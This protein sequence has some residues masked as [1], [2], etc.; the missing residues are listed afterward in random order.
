MTNCSVCRDLLVLEPAEQ[1]HGREWLHHLANHAGRLIPSVQ[2]TFAVSAS[3]AGRLREELPAGPNRPAVVAL[4]PRETALCNHRNL[5]V[6]AF[7]RWAAMRRLLAE[8][9]HRHGLFL[10]MD[11]LTLPLALGLPIGRGRSVSGILFRPSVHYDSRAGRHMADR[12]RDARKDLLYRLML[13]HP[14][15][16]TVH[17]LDDG[18]PG[19]ARERYPAGEKVVALP[20]P[21]FPPTRSTEA[22]RALAGRVPGG[23]FVLVLFGVLTVRKGVLALLRASARLD[24]GTAGRIA[25]VIA[26]EPAPE[27]RQRLDDAVSALRTA[28][29]G[30]WLH[31]EPRRLSSGEIEALI[32]R[33]DCVLAPY[34][35]F[36]GSSG[37]LMWAAARGRP[38]IAQDY[39]LVGRLV[40]EH[41]LGIAVDTTDPPALAAAMT[42]A[43]G[44][45]AGELA[46]PARMAA[47]AAGRTPEAFAAA[48]VAPSLHPRNGGGQ[49]LPR[50]QTA[51]NARL[52]AR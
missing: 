37:V 29:P 5:V 12:L 35:R 2:L 25:L 4:A 36:V 8:S 45:A 22:D 3:L 7:A 27:I 32:E 1:G 52:P 20:D 19:F 34:Q 23:R 46:D 17:T 16:H 43:A 11:H 38:V 13:P 33:C 21:A 44:C 41:G 14:A 6:S 24:A 30:L 39:G 47:F 26:G 18:F 42:A 48:L 15:L 31:V 49:R 10:E 50:H 9:G 51:S 40:R 28:Q